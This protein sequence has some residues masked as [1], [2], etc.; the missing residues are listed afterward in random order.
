MVAASFSHVR[1]WVFDLD[2][3]LYHPDV[4]LFDQIQVRMEH[5]VARTLGVSLEE[6]DRLRAHYWAEYGTTLSGLMAE[7]DLDP[8]PFLDDV[9]DINFDVLSPDPVL[10]RRI[11]ALPG[12]KIV[13]TNGS[14][15]YA[16]QVLQKRGLSGLF[17]AVYGIEHAGFRP[18]PAQAA[19]EAVF[20][21][22]D[23]P[24]QSG[25]MFEDDTR[26][27]EVPHQMGMRTV[28]VGPDPLPAP[29]IHHHT[30]DLAD[31]L[32]QVI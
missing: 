8:M 22:D 18:K 26:N 12:R 3:T 31:F 16:E 11:D 23:L 14:R 19:F 21:L 13:F 9:H 29:H 10:A 27:L 25:A 7:H 20:A 2:N 15:P 32:S 28:H 24:A 4:K 30:D 5:Y 6:A 1:V 17:D